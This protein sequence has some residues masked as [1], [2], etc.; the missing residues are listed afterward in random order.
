MD[1]FEFRYVKGHIEVYLDGE[2]ILSADTSRE[3]R[4]E[5]EGMAI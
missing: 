2:F 4:E 5:L 1:N 3:A